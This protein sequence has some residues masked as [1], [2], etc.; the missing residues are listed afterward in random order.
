MESA[1]AEHL[2]CPRT[3]ERRVADDYT[4]AH[5]RSGLM[6]GLAMT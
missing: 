1:I 4:R 2:R 3:R 5:A 6:N